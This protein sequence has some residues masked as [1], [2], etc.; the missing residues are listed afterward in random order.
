MQE[1][2]GIIKDTEALFR[3]R[4]K[5]AS[6]AKAQ[7]NSN[8]ETKQRSALRPLCVISMYPSEASK[9]AN[10]TLQHDGAHSLLL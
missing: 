2:E 9:L 3:L 6:A 1:R 4:K 7:V 8:N 10:S 5:Q